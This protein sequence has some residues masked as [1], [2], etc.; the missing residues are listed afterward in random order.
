MLTVCGHPLRGSTFLQ[1]Y[2]PAGGTPVGWYEDGQVAAVEHASGEGK[3]MLVGTF[4]GAGYGRAP[5]AAGRAWFRSLLD[6]AGVRQHVQAD[7]PAVT[8]R[9]HR[10]DGLFLWV[11]NPTREARTVALRCSQPWGP[12][13]SA[14]VHWGNTP[15]LDGH[16]IRVRVEGRDAAVLQLAT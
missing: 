13:R 14:R 12:F 16:A 2:E 11:T 6:W 3:T 1:A 10:G 4:P 8:A 7:D 9:L 15:E 5:S